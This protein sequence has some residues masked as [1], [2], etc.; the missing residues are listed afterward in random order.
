MT[1]IYTFWEN[2]EKKN[3]QNQDNLH[4]ENTTYRVLHERNNS[5][6][7]FTEHI[8]FQEKV[9]LA[10]AFWICCSQFKEK[11]LESGHYTF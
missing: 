1:L 2:F 5:T 6:A 7:S 3:N 10:D 11:K 9:T 8:K 4:F